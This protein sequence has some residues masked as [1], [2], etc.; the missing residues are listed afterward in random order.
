MYFELLFLIVLNL[1]EP[2]VL[3]HFP[4]IITIYVYLMQSDNMIRKVITFIHFNW[5]EEC[6][7]A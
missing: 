3:I 6:M 1:L 7:D 2:T 4:S 5:T